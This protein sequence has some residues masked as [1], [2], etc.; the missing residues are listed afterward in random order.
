MYAFFASFQVYT[1]SMPAHY[2]CSCHAPA[3]AQAQADGLHISVRGPWPQFV[4]LSSFRCRAQA[5]PRPMAAGHTP[6]QPPQVP[7]HL[8]QRQTRTLQQEGMV[9]RRPLR[10]LPT[11]SP[12]SRMPQARTTVSRATQGMGPRAV[13]PTGRALAVAHLAHSR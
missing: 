13:M 7:S 2:A 3:S 1:N 8:Q 12:H 6:Q 5:H 9:N 4:C 11:P 10:Q